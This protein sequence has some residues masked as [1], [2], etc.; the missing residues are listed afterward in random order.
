M[1]KFREK[2]SIESDRGFEP[3]IKILLRII[4][5]I[6]EKNVIGRTTLSLEANI[7]YSTLT[8]YF[9]WL[10]SKSLIELV[11]IE[12]KINVKLTDVGKD[13]AAQLRKLGWTVYQFY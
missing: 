8:K 10:E 7:N 3:N 4:K 5:I 6:L 9:E 11:I 2:I 13:F 12:G 1:L